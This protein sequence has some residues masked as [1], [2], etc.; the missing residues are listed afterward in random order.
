MSIESLALW[1]TNNAELVSMIIA[2]SLA[3]TSNV[4][5][6]SRHQLTIKPLYLRIMHGIAGVAIYAL[7]MR[8]L[9]KTT[10][11]VLSLAD[12]LVVYIISYY[13]EIMLALVERLL[14]EVI[15]KLVS[16]Y[17]ERSA[18][19]MNNQDDKLGSEDSENNEIKN[20]S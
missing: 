16:S 7:V 20:E 2:I 8:L 5:Y 13:T 4:L 14:P 1:A 17:L 6:R 12:L 10:N 19:K 3:T 15:N 18:S 11:P 9:G